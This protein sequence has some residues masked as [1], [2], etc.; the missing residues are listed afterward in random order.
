MAQP[1]IHESC[2]EEVRELR[3]VSRLTR[4]VAQ[5]SVITVELLDIPRAP[6]L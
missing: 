5:D 4:I 6:L 3:A 2:G 1:L